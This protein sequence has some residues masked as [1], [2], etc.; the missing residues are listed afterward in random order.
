MKIFIYLF[1]VIFSFCVFAS[2]EKHIQQ[3]KIDKMH[4]EK[5]VD[6]ISTSIMDEISPSSVNINVSSNQLIIIDDE[7]VPTKSILS[8]IKRLGYAVNFKQDHTIKV[9]V[10]GIVCSFCIIGIKK[11]FEKIKSVIDVDFDL[12]NGVLNLTISDEDSLT[13]ETINEIFLDAGYEVKQ[14]DR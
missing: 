14:I 1:M 13:N 10:D 12:E 5:C 11:N 7:P 4:C 6:Q 8:I 2:N 9:K 3:L